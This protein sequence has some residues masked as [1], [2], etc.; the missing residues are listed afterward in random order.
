M[1]YFSKYTH[2]TYKYNTSV[3][4]YTFDLQ[5]IIYNI[6][7]ILYYRKTERREYSVIIV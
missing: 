3:I 5:T 2:V 7:N 1:L 6:K 4:L